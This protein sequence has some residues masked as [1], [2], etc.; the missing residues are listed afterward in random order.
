MSVI[1]MT[2]LFYKA[3]LLQWEIWCWSLLGLIGLSLYISIAVI[4][5]LEIFCATK[6]QF[7]VICYLIQFAGFK[8]LFNLY[9]VFSNAFI[10]KT[11][12]NTSGH[13]KAEL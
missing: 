2:T 10:L 5:K 3:L 6:M 8:C 11:W 1:L 12:L 9:I 13:L 4:Q 7:L